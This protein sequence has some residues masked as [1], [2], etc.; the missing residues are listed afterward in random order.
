ERT[1]RRPNGMEVSRMRIPLGVI[2]IIYESRPNVTT[3]AAALC[4]KAGN[5]AILRG[6]KEAMHSNAELGRIVAAAVEHG[7]LPG[8]AVQVIASSDRAAMQVL[9]QQ[10]Q[11]I[12]LVIPR[13]GEG[14][15]RF[16]SE[17]SRIPVIKHFKGVCHLYIHA[18]ADIEMAL[19]LA[20]NAKIQRPGT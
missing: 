2:A 4:V 5:A 15:I 10:D 19:A 13:G 17:A 3:D 7:G 12:D 9:L 16:V 14:L 20:E 11:W 8:T 6:G 18:G 1:E